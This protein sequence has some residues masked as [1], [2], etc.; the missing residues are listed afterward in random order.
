MHGDVVPCSSDITGKHRFPRPWQ[1]TWAAGS[2]TA[3]V[4]TVSSPEAA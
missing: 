3:A 4:P 2:S 1:G